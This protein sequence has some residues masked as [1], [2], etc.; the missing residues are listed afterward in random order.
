MQD[1]ALSPVKV[2]G[3]GDE[4]NDNKRKEKGK[5]HFLLFIS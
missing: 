5:K 2:E 4:E 3:D 1:D